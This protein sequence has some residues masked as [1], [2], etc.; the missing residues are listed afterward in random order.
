M[1]RDWPPPAIAA[2]DRRRAIER[3]ADLARHQELDV[4]GMR[5]GQRH[6]RTARSAGIKPALGDRVGV[7]D[8]LGDHAPGARHRRH[9][10]QIGQR[11][12]A[13]A[14]FIVAAFAGQEGPT[15]AAAGSVEG[16]SVVVLAVAVA[17]V[18]VPNRAARRVGLQQTIDEAD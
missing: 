8:L 4:L 12:V 9:R 18:A 5:P 1:S 7:P 15:P 13:G 16:S 14:Q 10:L 2:P 11:V 6:C 17:A 3:M